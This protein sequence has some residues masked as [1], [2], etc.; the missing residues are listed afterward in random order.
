MKMFGSLE[1]LLDSSLYEYNNVCN[2]KPTTLI[3][4][5]KKSHLAYSIPL[6][7]TQLV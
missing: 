6:K 3:L 4:Y 5:S 1:A 7:R 2:H